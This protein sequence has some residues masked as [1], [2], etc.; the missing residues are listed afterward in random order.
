MVLVY[1]NSGM[2]PINRIFFYFKFIF[3]KNCLLGWWMECDP[4]LFPLNDIE[5]FDSL[6]E[7]TLSKFY[8]LKDWIPFTQSQCN[9]FHQCTKESFG[10]ST[11]SQYEQHHFCD[12]VCLVPLWRHNIIPNSPLKDTP[13]KYLSL[14]N[15]HGFEA[16]STVLLLFMVFH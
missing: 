9:L 7:W 5:L 15:N 8:L 4:T 3:H 14:S 6:L 13:L 1:F 2:N 12:E 10:F 11:L 16:L